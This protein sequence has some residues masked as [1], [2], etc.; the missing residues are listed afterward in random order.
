MLGG[1][2]T[3]EDAQRFAGVERLALQA[4]SA[5]ALVVSAPMWNYGAPYVVKQYFDCVLHPGLTFLER[6]GMRPEGL[7]GGGRPLVIVTSSGGAAATD[8]LTPW[9][10]DVG[11]MMGF[12]N[13]VVV[14]APGV[15]HGDRQAALD[16]IAW[17][18]VEA[19]RVFS[20]EAPEQAAA[21]NQGGDSDEEQSWTHE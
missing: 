11:A 18:A 2:D 4:A 10:R 6:P 14:A 9:L 21:D 12:D 8:H 3:D 16:R 15:P 13:A 17:S 1:S 5:G 19:A 7:L 20:Q